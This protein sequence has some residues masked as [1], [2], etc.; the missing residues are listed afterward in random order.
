MTLW[1]SPV[2]LGILLLFALVD[3]RQQRHRLIDRRIQRMGQESE[4]MAMAIEARNNPEERREFIENYC[5]TMPLH[6]RAGHGL[7]VIDP[8]GG[9]YRTGQAPAPDTVR[10]MPAVRRLL[11]GQNNSSVWRRTN[12]GPEALISARSYGTG[13]GRNAPGLI[14]YSESI[15]DIRQLSYGLI[16]GRLAMLVAVFAL[17][18]GTIWLFVK[19]RITRPLNSL[20]L[21]E[22]DVGEGDLA[23]RDHPDPHN[24]I[25][26]VCKMFNVMVERIRAHEEAEEIPAEKADSVEWLLRIRRRLHVCDRMLRRLRSRGHFPPTLQRQLDN[27]ERTLE[28]LGERMDILAE[29][30]SLEDELAGVFSLR[31]EPDEPSPSESEPPTARAAKS[32]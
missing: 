3:Y 16:A 5:E 18:V 24:E 8:T 1:I 25:S 31:D 21:H 13:K 15:D 6:G 19:H 32:Q 10:Q 11:N 22:W 7:L 27:L 29:R 14:Y 17:L 28:D 9:I 4:L 23:R 2:I 30:M 26:V 12:D 20:L